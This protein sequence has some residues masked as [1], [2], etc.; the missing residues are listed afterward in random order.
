SHYFDGH[1]I[2]AR[3]AYFLKKVLDVAPF[4]ASKYAPGDAIFGDLYSPGCGFWSHAH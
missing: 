1:F 2:E 4:L 3:K